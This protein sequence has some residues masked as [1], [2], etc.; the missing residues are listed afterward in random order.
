MPKIEVRRMPNDCNQPSEYIHPD[1][2]G[3]SGLTIPQLVAKYRK[4]PR[5]IGKAELARWRKL[6]MLRDPQ[7]LPPCPPPEKGPPPPDYKA[8]KILCHFVCDRPH[9]RRNGRCMHLLPISLRENLHWLPRVICEFYGDPMP[10]QALRM[11]R[12]YLE[13]IGQP[14]EPAPDEPEVDPFATIGGD[15]PAPL[16]IRKVGD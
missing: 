11:E 5:R 2:T 10:P 8:T 6:G 4:P 16:R 12:I 13:E 15:E 7:S 1:E 3:A 14:P 9:C